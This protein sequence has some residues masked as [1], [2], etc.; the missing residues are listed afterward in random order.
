MCIRDRLYLDGPKDKFFT[1]IAMDRKSEGQRIIGDLTNGTEIEYL[2][3]VSI[4]DIITAE[5]DAIIKTL[6]NNNLPVREIRIQNL[7]EEVL[8][9]LIMHFMLET[10]IS[11]GL[12]G[13]NP[14]DQPAV[15]QG[16]NLTRE[17]LNKN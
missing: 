10:I 11:A 12:L 6:A 4:G 14:F 2:K 5:Q 3:N 16:K 17:L 7:N 8:G 1:I 13:V 9:G 15:E